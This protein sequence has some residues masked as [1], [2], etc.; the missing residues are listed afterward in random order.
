M[1]TLSERH[2]RPMEGS[3]ALTAEQVDNFRGEIDRGWEVATDG[4]SIR[5]L[6]KFDDYYRTMAFVN[7]VAWV[8][9]RE[10]HH[11]DLLVSYNRCEVTFSTHSVGG[12]S[13]NDL[14]CA[15]KLDGLER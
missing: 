15:A 6:F 7:A 3:A 1:S 2:C 10:D 4:K 5:R 12:L 13:E 9:H 14:I 8:A 11:P